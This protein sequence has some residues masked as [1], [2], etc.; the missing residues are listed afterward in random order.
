MSPRDPA[1]RFEA[2]HADMPER[3]ADYRHAR[4]AFEERERVERA[5]ATP[6]AQRS[7]IE[8]VIISYSPYG[9]GAGCGCG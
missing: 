6:P 7:E 1:F 8:W 5:L 9:S 4:A 2:L 3:L